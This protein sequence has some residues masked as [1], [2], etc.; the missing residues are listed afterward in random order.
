MN[1]KASALAAGAILFGLIL[2]F[3]INMLFPPSKPETY[4]LI[5][6]QIKEEKS[7]IFND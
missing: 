3:I 2:G 4:E 1:T 5:P 6:I 7:V